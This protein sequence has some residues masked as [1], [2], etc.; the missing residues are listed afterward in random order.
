MEREREES[1]VVCK[2]RGQEEKTASTVSTQLTT[3]YK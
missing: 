3:L 1:R 2:K